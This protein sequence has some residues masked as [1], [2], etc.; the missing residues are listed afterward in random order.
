[1]AYSLSYSYRARVLSVGNIR[2]VHHDR[3]ESVAH[4]QQRGSILARD[5]SLHNDTGTESSNIVLLQ[6]I[7]HRPPNEHSFV[8]RTYNIIRPMACARTGARTNNEQQTAANCSGTHLPRDSCPA[9][10]L[11]YRLPEQLSFVASSD[12]ALTAPY[13]AE[14]ERQHRPLPRCRVSP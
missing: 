4:G 5:S 12:S 3:R 8:R 2:A 14:S 9:E 13:A 11:A 1:M 6:W 7:T 10:Q